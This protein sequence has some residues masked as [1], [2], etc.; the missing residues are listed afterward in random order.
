VELLAAGTQKGDK[1]HF[2]F[3]SNQARPDH[4]MMQTSDGPCVDCPLP[5]T[6]HT[7]Q[8]GFLQQ[9][10]PFSPTA[11][12]VSSGAHGERS[13][14]RRVYQRWNYPVLAPYG[15]KVD[16]IVE[17]VKDVTEQEQMRVAATQAEAYRQADQLKAELLGTVSHE[18]RSPIAVIK[19][20]TATLLRHETRLEKE[21][22]G[23]F[24]QAIS[25]ACDRLEVMVD[26]LLEMSQLETGTLVPQFMLVNLEQLVRDAGS[27]LENRLTRGGFGQ[28]RV[29]LTVTVQGD[30]LPLVQADPRLLRD[31]LD[32]VLENALN[33]SPAGGTITV[34]MRVAGDSLAHAISPRELI[35]SV[36]DS[37]I[38]IPPEHLD[39]VFD[40]FH[41]VDS[42]L[43]REVNGLGLG[44]AICKRVVELHGGRI[45][46]ESELGEG[47]TFYLSLPLADP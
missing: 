1:Q 18:L 34:T 40:R 44:L 32:S 24:L 13:L 7:K 9:E 35:I 37:G 36:A 29:E 38:G 8:A 30:I 15:T 46:G 11:S 5:K 6:V 33:Y 39:R 27:A 19:G 28:H 22:R 47:S 10:W 23:E 25:G 43:T 2:C 14:N 4:G 42:G 45:W 3:E 12:E 20:Y 17:V 16:Y 41:R 31:A 26:Q 21:E